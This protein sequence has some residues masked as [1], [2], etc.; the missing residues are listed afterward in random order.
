M[1]PSS[2]SAWSSAVAAGTGLAAGALPGPD[3]GA[4]AWAGCGGALSSAAQA[5][6]GTSAQSSASMH[7]FRTWWV[8][9][10]GLGMRGQTIVDDG[11][12]GGG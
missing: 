8:L 7:G 4:L 1:V 9:F 5:T 6:A 12:Q 10:D 11:A 2:K 3:D